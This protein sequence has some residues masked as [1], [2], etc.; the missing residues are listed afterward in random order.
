[1]KRLLVSF[2]YAFEGLAYLFRT[3]PNAR[4]HLAIA[5]A[6]VTAGLWLGLP[7][8]DW[9]VLA[10]AIGL[11]LAMEALNTAVEA[12]VDVTSP[13]PHPMAKI[14]KDVAAAG[15]LLAAMAAVAVGVIVLGGGLWGAVGW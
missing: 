4:I 12:V 5:A 3:Q 10:L 2:R 8:R 11:V 7:G 9:A 6:V 13:A 1:M 14:A 15:V